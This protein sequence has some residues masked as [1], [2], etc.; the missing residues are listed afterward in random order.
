MRHTPLKRLTY[1]E[2]IPIN[3]SLQVYRQVLSEPFETHWH[4]FYEIGFVLAGLGEHVLNGA[5][6]PLQRGS[7]F[8]LTPADFHMISPRSGDP[9]V[10]FNVIFQADMLKEEVYRLLFQDLAC[11]HLLFSPAEAGEIER[12]FERLLAESQTCKVGSHLI[13]A[14]ALERILIELYRKSQVAPHTP[15]EVATEQ[16]QK[17]SMSLIYVHHHFREPLC[18]EEVARQVHL[19]PSYFSE[20]FHSVYGISFQRY[21]QELRLR[22]A[23]SLLSAAQLPVS[24]ICSASGF[25]TLS[26]F[27]RAFKQRF[28]LSPRQFSKERRKSI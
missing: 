11:Y 2:H 25:Q 20:C 27:E 6:Q 13:M 14:G 16:H 17:L 28:G 21:L 1:A 24:H 23:I 19:S 12:D 26:H 4:D 22:F 18:L 10:L 3:Q 8:L 15:R 7:L 5:T 9:L